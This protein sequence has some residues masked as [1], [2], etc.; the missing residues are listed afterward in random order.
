MRV[1]CGAQF[2]PR[3]G[4]FVVVFVPFLTLTPV[5]LVVFSG[6]PCFC[7]DR[8]FVALFSVVLRQRQ[9]LDSSPSEMLVLVYGAAILVWL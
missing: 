6:W 1:A 4:F 7:L 2:H 8:C 9:L 3:Y 5:A